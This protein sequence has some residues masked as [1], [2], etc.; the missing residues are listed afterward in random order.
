MR[1]FNLLRE[2]ARDFDVFLFSFAENPSP[3]DWK[4]VLEICAKVIAVPLPRYREPRW[5]TIAPPE[6]GEFHAPLMQRLLGHVSAEYQIALRQ[7][8]YTHMAPYG[9]DIL[10]EHDVTFDLY[11]QVLETGTEAP[12]HD[13]TSSDG[14][15]LSCVLSNSFAGIVVMSEKDAALLGAPHSLVIPNGVDLGAIQPRPEGANARVWFSVGSFRHFPNLVAFRFLIEEV[16]PVVVREIPRATAVVIAGPDFDRYWSGEM[17]ARVELH[18][19]I[20]DVRPFYGEAN[21]VVVPT[22]VS[23]GTNLRRRRPWRWNARSY[24]RR[25]AAPASGWNMRGTRGSPMMQK[26]SLAALSRC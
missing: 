11:S 7:V 13:G 18:G 24:R 9:G 16:W 1:I 12:A 3:D 19:F 23:A 5:S 21:V 2:A 22:K 8:E 17:P 6:A 14:G 25:R 26:D 15:G 20:S 4:P 10:V